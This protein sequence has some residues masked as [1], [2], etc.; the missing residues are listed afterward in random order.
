[1]KRRNS[2][3]YA[4][5]AL[6]GVLWCGAWVLLWEYSSPGRHELDYIVAL[7]LQSILQFI[8]SSVVVAWA[9]RRWILRSRGIVLIST[10]IA[11]PFAG[12]LIVGLLLGSKE[13]LTGFMSSPNYLILDRLK[14]LLLFACF[15]VYFVA[16]KSFVLIP[17]SLISI[18]T[19]RRIGR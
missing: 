19:L 3:F 17:L 8:V 18:L 2:L 6:I 7:Y 9:G 15:A 4:I 12:A 5:A 11:T 1:M 14:T 16:L 13:A 10:I